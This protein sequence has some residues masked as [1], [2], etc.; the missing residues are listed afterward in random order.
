MIRLVPWAA[1]ALALWGCARMPVSNA[2]R[3]A[4]S[5][6]P[7]AIRQLIEDLD[8]DAIETRDAAGRA[9]LAI[10]APAIASLER[11][12][13][14]GVDAE[15]RVRIE[16]VLTR[17]KGTAAIHIGHVFGMIRACLTCPWDG[18][19]L[20]RM[21]FDAVSASIA[22][23][24][25]PEVHEQVARLLDRYDVPS[26]RLRD[27]GLGQVCP[28]DHRRMITSRHRCPCMNAPPGF[29][30][31]MWSSS[32]AHGWVDVDL[33][34]SAPQPVRGANPAKISLA[35]RDRRLDL[36]VADIAGKAGVTIECERSAETV[37]LAVT[38]A[39][40]PLVLETVVKTAGNYA[41]VADA[42]DRIRIV[43]AERLK[44]GMVTVLYPL[45]HL[46]EL[47]EE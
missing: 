47:A 29:V 24:D 38:D 3:G 4:E 27:N 39:E 25:L 6:E 9:L 17:L 23:T 34:S 44:E 10:G 12:L 11:A 33:P 22:I 1:L 31:V 26:N 20:G 19:P 2:P 21:D 15:S 35:L 32:E 16:S 43:G 40:W 37:T 42:P 36:A 14:G 30:R 46:A 28:C 8:A 18:Q 7:Y 13:A 5:A 41:I 45:R